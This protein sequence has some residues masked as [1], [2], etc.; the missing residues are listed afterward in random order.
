MELKAPKFGDA[1]FTSVKNPFNGI[2]SDRIDYRDKLRSRV[3]NPFNG[4][5]RR[6]CRRLRPQTRVCTRIHSMELKVGHEGT[7]KL[8][9]QLLGNPFNG[10]ER[11][12]RAERK[13]RPCR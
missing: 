1:S 12:P 8:L 10:I 9:S 3:W 6:G 5:E 11:E 13:M 4:I 7:A 2:E